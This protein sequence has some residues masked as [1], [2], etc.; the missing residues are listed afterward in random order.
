MFHFF[1]RERR[2]ARPKASRCVCRSGRGWFRPAALATVLGSLSTLSGLLP[3]SSLPSLSAQPQLVQP[4]QDRL[5][6]AQTAELPLD[7]PLRMA[8]EARRVYGQVRDYQGILITQERI[9]GVLLPEQVIQLSFRKEPFSV[10]MKWLAPKADAGQEVCYVTGK[11]QNKLKAL[12]ASGFGRGIGWLSFPIDDP[13]VT[14]HSRHK[15]TET[16]FGNLIDRCEKCWSDERQMNKNRV[17]I[18]EYEYNQ[19]RCMRVETTHTDR[20]LRFYCYRSVIY[21]DKVSKLPIRMECYDWPS[22]N[23]PEGQLLECFSYI[24]LEFNQNLPDSL[25]NK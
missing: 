22:Q 11:N 18:A 24:N 25:F 8:A 10:Y 20:D 6:P 14:A 2:R 17:Q 1:R 3:E 12:A 7:E 21:F 16:G 4:S 5:Q 15:I 19:R 23:A 13:K 9:K